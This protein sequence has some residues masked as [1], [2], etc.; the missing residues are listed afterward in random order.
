MQPWRRFNEESAMGIVWHLQCDREFRASVERDGYDAAKLL[1][2]LGGDVSK[3]DCTAE[4]PAL[5]APP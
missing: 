3:I 4:V 1:E 5:P 2:E